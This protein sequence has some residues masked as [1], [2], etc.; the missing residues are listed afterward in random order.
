MKKLVVLSTL[1]LSIVLISFSE[2]PRES[3]IIKHEKSLLTAIPL[4]E[5]LPKECREIARKWLEFITSTQKLGKN[6]KGL[7][8]ASDFLASLEFLT[9]TCTPGSSAS[10]AGLITAPED[11]LPPK[12][13]NNTEVVESGT[14]YAGS[15]PQGPGWELL[16]R[17]GIRTIVNLRQEDNTEVPDLDKLGLAHFYISVVDHYEPKLADVLEFLKIMDNPT[18]LPVYVH[19]H[20][21]VGRTHTFVAAWRISHGTPLEKAL[22]EARSFGFRHAPQV[23]FL[24]AFAKWWNDGHSLDAIPDYL[25][26]CGRVPPGTPESDGPDDD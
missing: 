15:Q 22:E 9:H 13:I 19:C 18:N 1:F 23:E 8:L 7:R 21:G 3:A 20:A 24:K 10:R 11:F 16:K 25:K 12:C 17:K 2:T 5:K 14:L 4:I 26:N 6:A